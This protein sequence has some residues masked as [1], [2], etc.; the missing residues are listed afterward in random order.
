MPRPQAVR[1]TPP[2]RLAIPPAAGAELRA[3]FAASKAAETRL[4]DFLAGVALALGID[5]DRVAGYDDDT[6]DLLLVPEATE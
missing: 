1:E 4:T 6:G 3:R 2:E 5:H